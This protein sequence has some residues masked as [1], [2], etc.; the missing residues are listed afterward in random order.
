MVYRLFGGPG[1]D[2]TILCRTWYSCEEHF[3]CSL[4]K[5]LDDCRAH[6]MCDT[7]FKYDVLQLETVQLVSDIL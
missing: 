5:A 1:R 6:V 4:Q 3:Y 2:C 7:C